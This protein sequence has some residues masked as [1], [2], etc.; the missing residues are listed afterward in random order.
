M[1]PRGAQRRRSGRLAEVFA[2]TRAERRAA[3]VAFLTAGDPS[4]AATSRLID[5]IERS[6]RRMSARA[7]W[8]A[9]AI[10]RA[11]AKA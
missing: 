3:F 5:A 2:T 10:W 8:S 9:T 4:M 11:S 7:R 1:S 6:R